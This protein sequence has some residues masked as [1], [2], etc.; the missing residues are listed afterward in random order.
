MGPP[1]GI[2]GSPPLVYFASPKSNPLATKL[3]DFH[4]NTM[5]RNAIRPA[6]GRGI[7]RLQSAC[8]PANLSRTRLLLSTLAVLEQ[9]DGQLNK[10][11]LGAITA[12]QKLGG[13]VHA[14]IAGSDATAAAQEASK[15]E[16]LEKILT[17][18]SG[19]YEK[20]CMGLRNPRT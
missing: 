5:L 15:T 1:R 8:H 3:Q 4:Q 20:V 14:F 12:A 18:N 9:R 6:V 10:G 11:S 19:A 13:T 7:G 16:G 17:V 2:P